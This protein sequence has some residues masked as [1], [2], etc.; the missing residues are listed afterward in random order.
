[1]AAEDWSGAAALITDR[2]VETHAASGTPAQLAARL[3]AYREAGLD[4][5]VISGVA[6]P[7]HLERLIAAAGMPSK[8][9]P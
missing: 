6:D 1:M 4:E 8:G 3:R 2:I 7:E 9:E 5:I